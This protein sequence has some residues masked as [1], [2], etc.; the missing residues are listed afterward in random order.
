MSAG[1]LPPAPG[2]GPCV[3]PAS[4][5][6]SQKMLTLLIAAP[7]ALAP[8]GIPLDLAGPADPADAD[9]GRLV[10]FVLPSGSA[11]ASGFAAEGVALARGV[12][13]ELG[14]AF[15]VRDA[16]EGAPADVAIAPLLVYQNFRG[17]SV[18]EG[19]TTTPE[20][21]RNFLRTA[22][23]APQ[24]G[25]PLVLEDVPAWLEGRARVGAPL[26]VTALTGVRPDGHDDGAFEAAVRA[27]LAAGFDT[28]RFVDR[29][30]LRRTDRRFYLDVHSYRDGAGR[31][32]VTT[33]VYSQFH[34][35]EP[36]FSRLGDPLEG[37]W[38]E[39]AALYAEVGRVLERV[40]V[41]TAASPDGGDGFEPLP[42]DLPA[43]A[44]DALGLA[45]PPAPERPAPGFAAA[46]LP[47]AWRLRAARPDD[48]PRLA[49]H[50]LSPLDGMR[51]EVGQVEGEL[52]LGPDRAFAG[53]AGW[54][55]AAVATVSMGDPALDEWIQGER[56][57]NGPGFP[58]ARFELERLALDADA[59]AFGR[60][61]TGVATGTFT[62]KGLSVP[63]TMRLQ[64]EAV[65]DDAGGPLL[66]AQGAFELPIKDPY[67]ME[68]PGGPERA[69]TTLAF[70]VEFPLV[71]AGD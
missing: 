67:G 2:K 60:L 52:V 68:G 5:A 10:A 61:T 21:L 69:N 24:G 37:T 45:L 54:V 71:P 53:A 16:R 7:L 13:D 58:R 22:R 4:R 12:A 59:L 70:D 14:V 47:S 32:F 23:V 62:L 20:R 28:L 1:T 39:R 9:R 56:R 18:Y 33:E 48:P 63:L 29:V 8:A 19:R 64:L 26:K 15:E 27:G 36:V 43:P 30:E 66:V 51:G 34:C 49:F 42:A 44:W 3:H 6:E 17:R 31:L 35:K 11:V 46:D 65:V 25:E 55:E 41:G 38:D 50:F 57:L 40:L